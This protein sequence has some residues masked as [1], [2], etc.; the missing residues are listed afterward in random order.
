[1]ITARNLIKIYTI[2]SRLHNSVHTS[3][4]HK[5]EIQI[6]IGKFV[7]IMDNVSWS[8]SLGQ[9]LHLLYGSRTFTKANCMFNASPF[10]TATSIT[11]YDMAGKSIELDIPPDMSLVHSGSFKKEEFEKVL[12]AAEAF[13]FFINT[14]TDY[15]QTFVLTAFLEFNF[16]HLK[17]IQ[18]HVVPYTVQ[19]SL[20]FSEILEQ[21][22]LIYE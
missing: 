8:L 17:C 19:E 6:D 2:C 1:M 3:I 18:G 12:D 22:D 15:G 9:N 21:E 11:V 16:Q 5:S 4:A 14:H 10:V 7:L 20:D 13:E